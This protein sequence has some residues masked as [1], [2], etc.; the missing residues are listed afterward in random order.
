MEEL[1]SKS[2]DETLSFGASFARR[3]KCGDVV[4]LSGDLGAGKTVLS[5]GI[6]QGL[7][8][9]RA[10]TS[11]TF[12]LLNIYDE[13]IIPLYH[14]DFYRLTSL[15]EAEEAGLGEYV[16]S[17]DAISLIEWA[18]R[19]KELLPKR[20]I[21]VEILKTGEETRKIAVREMD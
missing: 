2:A 6:A 8:I 10:I 13:G 12:T 7:G 4:A 16:G 17:S 1:E 3:L 9:T 21:E 5:K 11:P 14:F 19:A 20:H 18:D 15:E